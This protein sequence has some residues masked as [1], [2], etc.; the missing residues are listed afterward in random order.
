MVLQ[1]DVSPPSLKTECSA[2]KGNTGAVTGNNCQ[3]KESEAHRIGITIL[4][5]EVRT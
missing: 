2:L 4:A 5:A 1:D 3:S